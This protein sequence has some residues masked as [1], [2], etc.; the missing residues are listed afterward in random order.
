VFGRLVAELGSARENERQRIANN[1]HD[2][3]GQDL[4]LA[5]MKLGLLQ[6]TASNEQL[7][8]IREIHRLISNVVDE[9]RSLICDLYPQAVRDLGLPA[10][11]EWLVE[12]TRTNYG[13]HCLADMSSVPRSLPQDIAETIFFAAREILINVAKHARA[14]QA[15][16]LFRTAEGRM[17]IQVADDGKGFEPSRLASMMNPRCGGFGLVSIRERLSRIGGTM[18]IDSTPGHGTKVTLM[19]PRIQAEH[20]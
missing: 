14:K 8:T 20:T 12:R 17:L 13:L 6:R 2:Q 16:L 1:L 9:I 18:R 15:K 10:A 4:M 3:I 11:L 19:L 7:R 5:I